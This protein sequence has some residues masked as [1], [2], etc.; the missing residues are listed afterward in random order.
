[1]GAEEGGSPAMK[2]SGECESVCRC[3]NALVSCD[4]CH[5]GVLDNAVLLETVREW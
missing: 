5:T 4:R 1:M 2:I 3:I